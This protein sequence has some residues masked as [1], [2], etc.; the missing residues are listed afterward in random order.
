MAKDFTIK[1]SGKREECQS[2]MKREIKVGKPRFDLII[3][4]DQVYEET[5]LYRWAMILEKGIAKY[6]DRDWEKADSVKDL[7]RFKASA[8]RHFVQAMSN[9]T[10]EDHIAAVVFNLNA[11]V[12]LMD[13]LGVDIDG[14]TI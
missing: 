13:K 9:E 10:E 4:K 3:P 11:I 12:Y 7:E 2:G 8:F 14:D 1:D 6:G 5:L